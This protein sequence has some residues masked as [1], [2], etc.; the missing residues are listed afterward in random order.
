VTSAWNRVDD[1]AHFKLDEQLREREFHLAH[2][3]LHEL[4]HLVGRDTSP[5]EAEVE[6]VLEVLR[7]VRAKV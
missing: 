1:A 4:G 3:L 7:V 2:E 5:A 6:R